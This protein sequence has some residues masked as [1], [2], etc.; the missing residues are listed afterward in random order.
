[1]AA[2]QVREQEFQKFVRLEYQ[3]FDAEAFFAEI[4]PFVRTPHKCYNIEGKELSILIGVT[5]PIEFKMTADD[6]TLK[7]V[8][9]KLRTFGF[10]KA[11]WEWK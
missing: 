9:A 1:M 7:D 11:H 10:K 3:E 5:H 4:L 2:V 8:E 6:Q